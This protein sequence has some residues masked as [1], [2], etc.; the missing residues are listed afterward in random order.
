MPYTIY[1]ASIVGAQ[2]LLTALQGILAKA[3]AHPDAESFLTRRL[4]PDMY[5]FPYQIWAVCTLAASQAV[6]LKGDEMPPQG[7]YEDSPL[8]T[9]AAMRARVTEVL[10]LVG[11]VDKDAAVANADKRFSVQFRA[12][13][14][15]KELSRGGFCSGAG[16]PNMYFHTAIAYAIL[17]N[18]GV[19]LGKVDYLAPFFADMGI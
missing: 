15:K 11:T 3:E 4:A 12:G 2:R 16:M 7:E 10:A 18:G 6:A 19:E 8:E 9:Y 17:R 13:I 14:G 5:P 1:D